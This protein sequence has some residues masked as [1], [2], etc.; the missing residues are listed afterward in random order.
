MKTNT[1]N[2]TENGAEVPQHILDFCNCIYP[3]T[4][5]S[6]YD[7][8][9]VHLIAKRMLIERDQ[10]GRDVLSA[11]PGVDDPSEPPTTSERTIDSRQRSMPSTESILSTPRS[12]TQAE[13][14]RNEAETNPEQELRQETQTIANTQSSPAPPSKNGN[15][16]TKPFRG[17]FSP[18]HP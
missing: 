3:P 7:A 13:Q 4:L 8:D 9:R 11:P 2:Q 10:V 6:A 15:H 14:T 12:K 16:W 17:S 1:N 5:G 18:L